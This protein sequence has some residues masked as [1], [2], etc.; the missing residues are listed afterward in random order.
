MKVSRFNLTVKDGQDDFVYNTLTGSISKIGKDI[1]KALKTKDIASLDGNLTPLIDSGFIV[2]DNVDEIADYRKIHNEWKSGKRLSEFNMLITYD[3]N[4]ACPYC[5]QGR[6]EETSK[7]HNYRKMT[8]E[9]IKAFKDF[10]KRTVSDRG[11][12]DMSLILYGGEPML[13]KKECMETT[14]ELADWAS[15]NKVNFYLQA[16]SNGVLIDKPFIDWASGYKMRIQI[17]VDG[18]P[19]QHNKLR[20]YKKT[21]KGSFDDITKVLGMLRETD[22]ETHI[23]ISLTNDTYPTMERMLDTLKERGLDHIYTDFCYI[24]AFTE[25]CEGFKE[26]T[27]SDA[28]L[29]DVM[30]KLWRESHKRGFK[31]DVRPYPQALPCS[32]IAD[33]S[34]IVDPFM[35]V[36]KCWELVGLKEHSVGKLDERGN[37]QKNEIYKEVLDRDPTQIEGCKDH[38]Y[39][40]SCGGGCVCKAYWN[41]GTYNAKGCGSENF[42]LPHRVRFYAE[43]NNGLDEVK[44]DQIHILS[45]KVEPKMK[46]CYVLV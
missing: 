21:G 17:P 13:M 22:V 2:D 12:K 5:Y 41:E 43:T 8:P 28:K 4:F 23:R 25:A 16:L 11:S 40:P 6:D 30:P 46:H 29:F 38:I 18:A 7:I 9:N 44:P 31:Q 20:F 34:Y 26:H 33:G 1:A 14:D 24:T 10:V 19:E 37:I 36:Y 35:E 39:L 45:G 15:M 42:L 27:L 32:S 3:C